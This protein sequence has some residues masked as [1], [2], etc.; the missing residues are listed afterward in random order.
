MNDNKKK[1]DIDIEDM[2][3]NTDT[4]ID[5]NINVNEFDISDCYYNTL[6]DLNEKS[7]LALERN[8]IRSSFEYK[9]Y[10]N[11]LKKE[12]N[13]TSCPLMPGIDITTD[14]VTLEFH[15]H[16]ITL[17]DMTVAVASALLATSEGKEV[18]GFDIAEQVM[19]EHYEN[20]V[21][22]IPLTSTIHEMAHS[23]AIVVPLEC[24]NG[25]YKNFYNK[26]KE[27]M[28]LE[29]I[30][31]IEDNLAKS[32]IANIKQLNDEKL[33]K[34]ILFLNTTYNTSEDNPDEDDFEFFDE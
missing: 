33:D 18:S 31:R 4:T 21:G 34:K 3:I 2:P 27:F 28:P 23:G 16:P 30:E 13:L 25:N 5:I 8:V 14:P 20:N 26:Y 9:N 7:I 6:E 24:V 15:H 17:Y 19:K 32:N 29:S 1:I 10:I 11:Y 22:L 12:L